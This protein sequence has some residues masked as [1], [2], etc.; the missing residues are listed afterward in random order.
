M[1]SP[2]MHVGN[3]QPVLDLGTPVAL[4]CTMEEDGSLHLAAVTSAWWMGPRCVLG[5]HD[6]SRA[7]ANLRRTREVVVNMP[8]AGQAETVARLIRV[9]GR[10]AV[11]DGGPERGYR[12]A[13]DRIGILG[14]TPV[15]S[16]TVR[17]PRV[18]ECPIQLEAVL[19]D[20]H[21]PAPG[22]PLPGDVAIFEVRV[23]RLH[24]DAS[25]LADGR[26]DRIDPDRWRP[27][28]MGSP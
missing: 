1:R 23:T 22:S 26:P 17:P 19:D 8:A 18:S 24:L 9:A 20:V 4:L 15:P 13:R 6:V 11:P 7:S 12:C 3:P 10:A 14:L 25:V 2:S 27:L 21:A 5:L 28:I 16:E